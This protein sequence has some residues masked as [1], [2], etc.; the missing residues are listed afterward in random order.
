MLGGKRNTKAEATAKTGPRSDKELQKLRRLDLLELLIDQI[1]ENEEQ[2]AELA[3][4]HELDARLKEK[5]D[6]K[7][8]Q[9]ERLKVKLDNKDAEIERLHD[10]NRAI[11]HN[12]GMLG[13]REM[14]DIEKLA[15]EQYLRQIGTQGDPS[16]GRDR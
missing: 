14:L 8:A 4:L 9:I 3:R 16:D 10:L 6:D 11:A 5:L 15:V 12:G 13:V 2:A 1:R 7:D